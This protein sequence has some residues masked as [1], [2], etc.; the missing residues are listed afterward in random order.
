MN[1]GKCFKFDY[2]TFVKVTNRLNDNIKDSYFRKSWPTYCGFWS[3][4]I[5]EHDLLS[6]CVAELVCW[7]FFNI[8]KLC[9]PQG[10]LTQD[11]IYGC[12]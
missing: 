8:K 2:L 5:F 10:A 6:F 7:G 3:H 1:I 4:L 9:S 12:T 11:P